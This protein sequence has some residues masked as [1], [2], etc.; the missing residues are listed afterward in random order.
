[1]LDPKVVAAISLAAG[2]IGGFLL[3]W[4]LPTARKVAEG[5]VERANADYQQALKE[6]LAAHKTPSKDDDA[7]AEAK[8]KAA[9]NTRD[10]EQTW[11][12]ALDGIAG[13][14]K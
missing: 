5:K 6:E 2:L 4:A 11:K 9:R 8:A 10:K 3:R 12:D 7:A 14:V 1:M 13:A